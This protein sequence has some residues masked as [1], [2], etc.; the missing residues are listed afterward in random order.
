MFHSRPLE[1]QGTDVVLTRRDD[2][3]VGG[4]DA[5]LPVLELAVV[6]D[7]HPVQ[8]ILRRA[9]DLLGDQILP[10]GAVVGVDVVITHQP[11]QPLRVATRTTGAVV[12]RHQVFTFRA[13]DIR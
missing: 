11:Q 8:A 10:V 7:Y 12:V 1:H 13:E 6:S 9:G 3:G 4:L 5:E 2:L